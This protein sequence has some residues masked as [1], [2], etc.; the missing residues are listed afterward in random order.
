MANILKISQYFS[1][2]KEGYFTIQKAA[3]LVFLSLVLTLVSGCSTLTN[4]VRNTANS[5]QNPSMKVAKSYDIFVDEFPEVKASR[6][7]SYTFRDVFKVGDTAVIS[8][9]NVESLSGSHIVN[10]EGDVAFPLIGKVKVAGKNTLE[11]QAEL[12][13]K[14]GV[15]FLQNPSIS[16]ELD[17][18][19]LGVIVVD[20]AVKKT[21]VF[22][23]YKAVSL[24][25]AIALAGG[26]NEDANRKE[27]Y[28]VR[29]FDGVRKVKSVNLDE[30][31]TAG[32]RDP[33][34]Y[35]NDL[36]F[37]QESGARIAFREVLRTIPLIN[38]MIIIATR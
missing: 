24:S 17:A 19:K 6:L 12:V 29:E 11:L 4:P 37:V 18:Q 25:E 8:V 9:F 21:G 27:V 3:H 30:I 5:N 23:I 2:I 15:K 36:V 1:T 28:L 31:R 26:L 34:I 20:G 33:K 14:Y 38:T 10:R 7:I 22:D 32:A 35:P 16:V 13:K